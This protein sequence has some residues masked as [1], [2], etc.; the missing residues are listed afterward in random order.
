MKKY[1]D[2]RINYLLEQLQED[3]KLD[4]E[5]CYRDI[6]C[7]LNELYKNIDKVVDYTKNGC[8]GD[9]YLNSNIWETCYY[10]LSQVLKLHNL[11][12]VGSDKTTETEKVIHVPQKNRQFSMGGR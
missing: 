11:K 9:L 7:D 5:S 8:K 10:T 1:E 6:D 4:E 12:F 2:E 3:I